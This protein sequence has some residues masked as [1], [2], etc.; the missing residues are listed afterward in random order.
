MINFIMETPTHGEDTRAERVRGGGY[1]VTT[2]ESL[3]EPVPLHLC[4]WTSIPEA[5]LPYLEYLVVYQHSKI[6]PHFLSL[7]TNM[8]FSLF[9]IKVRGRGRI[10]SED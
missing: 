5:V 7:L 9:L 8:C 10:V 1:P 4:F 2:C 6:Y 3:L